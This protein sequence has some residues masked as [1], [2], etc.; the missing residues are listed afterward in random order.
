MS[1]A[2]AL[3]L[4]LMK[5]CLTNWIYG[6]CEMVPIEPRGFLERQAAQYFAARGI[7]MVQSQPFDEKARAE[8]RYPWPQTAHT[9]IGLKRLDN[10]QF[11]VESVLTNNVP[12]DFIETGVWRGGSVIFMRAVLRAYGVTDR[13]VWV[14]DSFEGL[15]SPN[16][17]DYPADE[18]LDLTGYKV[19]AVSL[20]QVQS[21]FQ[22]YGLLDDKVRFLKGWFADTL[23][24]APISQLSLIRL[25][26]DLYESTMDA[27]VNLYPKLAVGGYVI[28]DDYECFAACKQ[29]VQDYRQANK[30]KDE[31]IPIDWSGVYWQR[32]E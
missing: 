2:K 28:V 30:I 19:L 5:R 20:E 24:I 14:A 26:G 4:D 18:G 23:P 31:I 25:D 6:D 32:T 22:R 8:G 21:N 7:E 1:D 15:P 3:Y 10:I 29:A 9:M 11:C 17:K 12:G 16:A 27:L 13:S